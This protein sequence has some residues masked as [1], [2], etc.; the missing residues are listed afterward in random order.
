ML[1]THSRDG[2]RIIEMRRSPANVLDTELCRALSEAL[3]EAGTADGAGATVLTGSGGVFSAGVDLFRV[4]ETGPDYLPEF[5]AAL[6]GLFDTAVAFPRPLVAAIDGHAIAGGAVLAFACDFRVMADGPA[7]IGVPELRV[8]VP[9]PCRALDVVRAAVPARHL[10]ETVLMG[11]VYG[12]AEAERKGLVDA[13]APPGALLD[14]AVEIARDLCRIPTR[15]YAITK[16]QLAIADRAAGPE[17][18]AILDREVEAAWR[19]EETRAHIRGYL[20]RT[21]GKS[22]R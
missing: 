10:R 1:E 8:G 17:R 12:A 7:T 5:L 18:V 16:R 14:R 22:S 4:L 11:R 9:F 20:E 3:S 21:L 6:D 19:A 15:A 2:I 13:L